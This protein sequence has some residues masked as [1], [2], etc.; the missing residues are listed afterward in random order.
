MI[1]VVS[2]YTQSDRFGDRDNWVQILVLLGLPWW[3]SGWPCASNAGCI[4][5]I[6]GQRIKIPHAVQCRKE[7]FSSA[8]H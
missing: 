8:L 5:P 6:P 2:E 4:G 1:T 3:S 7:K